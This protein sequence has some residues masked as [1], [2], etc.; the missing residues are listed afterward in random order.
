MNCIT[1]SLTSS[2]LLYTLCTGRRPVSDIARRQASHLSASLEDSTLLIV[3]S[4]SL[5]LFLAAQRNGESVRGRQI[6]TVAVVTF[7]KLASKSKIG[8][9]VAM[10]IERIQ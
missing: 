1:F 7:S 6:T 9:G 2:R 5:L 3:A 10:T 8:L 4:S